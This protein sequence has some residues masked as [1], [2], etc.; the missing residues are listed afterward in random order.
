MASIPNMR[1]VPAAPVPGAPA[2]PDAAIAEL[3]A[4]IIAG[5][6]P[7]APVDAAAPEIVS[8]A[9]EAEGE[10]ATAEGEAPAG[11]P[12][13]AAETILPLLQAQ[14][15]FPAIVAAPPAGAPPPAAP[16][17]EAP[18]APPATAPAPAVIA[19]LK[20]S[21]AVA[22]PT[23]P[24][25]APHEPAATE[26]EV[27]A[28]PAPEAKLAKPAFEGVKKGEADTPPQPREA[29]PRPA[30]DSIPVAE[31]PDRPAPVDIAGAPLT[32]QSASPPPTAAAS[33]PPFF[34]PAPPVSA[35]QP[36]APATPTAPAE[37]AVERELDL[38]RDGA[39]LDRLARDIARAGSEDGTMR[40]RLHPQTL[41]HMRVELSQSDQGATVR[42]TVETEA[43]RT[44]LVDAQP[45]LVAEAR[46][47]GVRLA[48]TEVDLAGAHTQTSG[49]PRRQAEA[50]A[51]PM[52]RTARAATGE[53]ALDAAS[54]AARSDRYA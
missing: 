43:A 51:Q 25:A 53:A 9:P 34:T 6:A 38:A 41:G 19:P 42:L 10:G 29:A 33:P 35:A 26:A 7:A 32:A 52:I 50:E 17:A 20:A 21:K 23:K 15:G 1:V 18:Q 54:A 44:I 5:G 3:F 36:A 11:A 12:A 31:R 24:G 39:W 14:S 28:A 2:T 30:T 46:A 48:G 49:D 45:R 40:F 37:M 22:P 13:E 8:I 27:A 47:Q 16:V 4:R